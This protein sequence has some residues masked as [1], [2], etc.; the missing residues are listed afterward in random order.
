MAFRKGPGDMRTR[1]GPCL[2]NRVSSRLTATSIGTNMLRIARLVATKSF[3]KRMARWL[4][5]FTNLSDNEMKAPRG[6]PPAGAVLQETAEGPRWCLT[7]DAL[8]RAAV[9][10]Q[11]HRMACRER[12][13]TTRAALLQAKPHLF[14]KNGRTTG[15]NLPNSRLP[16]SRCVSP[17]ISEEGHSSSPE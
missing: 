5:L 7:P 6:R 4:H 9:R 1:V 12:Y 3:G 13:R 8:E 15:R 16:L 14:I 2:L 11:E 10:L 17:C